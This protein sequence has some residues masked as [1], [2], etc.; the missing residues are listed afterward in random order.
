M[1][2]RSPICP[3]RTWPGLLDEMN[4]LGFSYRWVSRFLFLDKPEAER[5]L[6]R[7]RRQWFAKRKGVVTLLRETIFQ[8]ESPLGPVD[9][10]LQ[11]Q[12]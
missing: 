4:R 2:R 9:I 5:A 6:T 1:S 7:L 11:P 10:V 8:Q 3:S 12:A